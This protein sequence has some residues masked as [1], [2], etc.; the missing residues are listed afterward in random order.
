[1]TKTTFVI[2]AG[3]SVDFGMPTGDELIG[4]ISELCLDCANQD[5]RTNDADQVEQIEAFESAVQNTFANSRDNIKSSVV[6]ADYLTKI[7]RSL[8][9]SQSIDTYLNEQ[10]EVLLSDIGKL[11]IIA[12]ILLHEKIR[13]S[14]PS[15]TEDSEDQNPLFEPEPRKFRE[16]NFSSLRKTWLVS[17]FR[18]LRGQIHFEQLEERLKNTSLVIFNYDR[19]V[20]HFLFH[21]FKTFDNLTDARTTALLGNLKIVHPY[22]KIARLPWQTGSNA[23]SVEFGD[24]QNT[25]I[26][27]NNVGT[28]RTFMES[29]RA[30]TV[31]SIQ[32]SIKQSNCLVFFGFG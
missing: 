31:E 8:W 29:H 5:F 13:H 32:N 22:G 10:D 9:L 2:G 25:H 14:K 6:A 7:G 1:M 4:V 19:C 20:E 16:M 11:A 18:A 28:I 15:N 23:Q 30:K 26:A 17:F 27:L 24:V 3:A 21:A 12:S